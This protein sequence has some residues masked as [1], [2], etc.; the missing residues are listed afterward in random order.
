MATA[1]TWLRRAGL[2]V[3]AAAACTAG[4]AGT[5]RDQLVIG[6][7]MNNVLSLDPAGATGNDVLGVAANLYDYLVELDPQHITTVQPGLAE[8]WQIAPDR[9]SLSLTL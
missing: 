7:N 3:L 2:A 8:S 5:P 1:M 6:M 4:H 9:N